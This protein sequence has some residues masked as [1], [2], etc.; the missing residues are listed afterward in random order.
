MVLMWNPVVVASAQ[1]RAATF[2]LLKMWNEEYNWIGESL[3]YKQ[4]RQLSINVKL[5]RIRVTFLTVE[6][7]K[8]YIFWVCICSLSYLAYKSH[9]P[10]CGLWPI[11]LYHIFPRYPVNGTVF[12][13]TLLNIKY[14]FWFSVQLLSEIFLMLRRIQWD[15]TINVHTSSCKVHI[16]LVRF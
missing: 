14:A 11:G 7:R 16:I 12:G 8:A 15:I 9:A 6:K 4:Y 2:S 5:K 13:K 3:Y 10:Y 1:G